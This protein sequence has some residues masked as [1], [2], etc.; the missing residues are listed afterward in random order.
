MRTIAVIGGGISGLTAAYRLRT[1]LGEDARIVVFEATGSLG[2]KLR[3]VELAGERYDV[4]AEAFL[5]R[6]PEALALVREVGL[7]ESLVH[8][9]KTRAKIHAGGSVLGLPPGTVMGV[10][11]SADAVAGVLSEKGRALVEAESSLPPLKLHPG[12]VPLGEL[13]RARFGD[14]LVDRLVDPLLGGVYAGGADG[15]GLRAT[16]PGL[17][18]AIDRGARSLTEGAASLMPASP[19]TAPVFGTLLGGLGTLIARLA[20]LSR[21]EIR[22]EA[23]VTAIERTADGWKVDD[24]DADSVLLAVPAPSARRLLDGVAG[25]AS[26][27]FAKI[28]LASM[29]VVALALPPGTALPESSGVLI[30][31]GERDVAGRPFA[32]KAFTFSSRKW[33]QYGEGPVLVRGSVGRFGEPGALHA[34][35]DELVRVVRDDLARL[36][37]VTAEPI[38]TLVTRWGGGLPQY[39]IGHLIR[40]ERIERAVGGVPG[41]AVAGAAL[42]GVGIPACVATADAAARRIAGITPTHEGS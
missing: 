2:G 25:V 20:E 15:L 12:D 14:E 38:D 8:P 33:A 21:A 24:L 17:A 3:T 31:A 36:T 26:T 40:V 19:S 9:T 23:T 13:L 10:P 18:S 34:D 4:G 29:A 41:L 32:A 16:M 11:A 5:V 39:G 28:E 30:G 1:L 7:G 6:R 42:H 35:D 27:V 37:G 22:T